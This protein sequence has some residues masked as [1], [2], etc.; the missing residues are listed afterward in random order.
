LSASL[1]LS[2]V[3]LSLSSFADEAR[4]ASIPLVIL[5]AAFEGLA[6]GGLTLEGW[7]ECL[8]AL[9]GS[10]FSRLQLGGALSLGQDPWALGLSFHEVCLG[11]EQ[12]QQSC[13]DCMRS[14]GPC[15]RRLSVPLA[16]PHFDVFMLVLGR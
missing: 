3:V 12:G 15:L 7:E 6:H 14:S 10:L 1:H 11:D 9:V 2:P 16:V 4:D 13:L 8:G 5:L